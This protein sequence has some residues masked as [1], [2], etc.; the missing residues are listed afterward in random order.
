MTTAAAFQAIGRACL[1]H[2]MSNERVLSETR[3]PEVVHQMRVAMRR[4]RAAIS[5]FKDVLADER[6][7]AIRSE[8]K[9]ISNELGAA[10]DLDVFIAK[11]LEPVRKKH[12]DE[13]GLEFLVRS[14]QEQREQ[15]Y[16]R[17]LAAVAS[18]R[19]RTLVIDTAAWI[20]AGSWVMA[21]EGLERAKPVEVLLPSELARRAQEGQETRGGSGGPRSACPSSG[22]YRGQ[23]V[24]LRNGVLL[25]RLRRPQGEK[26]GRGISL[27]AGEPAGAPGRAQRPRREPGDAP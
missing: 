14:F 7:D 3:D 11:T 9:W 6:R 2:L 21:G 13:P 4:L 8:L 15:A 12:P 27:G 18:Q 20:E 22:A 17:A 26:A 16:D 25:A 23:E 19:F 5:L 1:H 24:A 10:R